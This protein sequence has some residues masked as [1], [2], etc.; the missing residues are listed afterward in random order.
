VLRRREAGP[1]TPLVW[2]PPG[3]Q[4]VQQCCG[5]ERQARPRPWSGGRGCKLGAPAGGRVQ[6]NPVRKQP[7]GDAGQSG[8]CVPGPLCAAAR[9]PGPTHTRIHHLCPPASLLFRLRHPSLPGAPPPVG[10]YESSL[11]GE[12]GGT[13]G[14]PLLPGPLG[15]S[16]G[17]APYV[18]NCV[19][20]TPSSCNGWAGKGFW[21]VPA[22]SLPGESA[23]RTD[24]EDL[25]GFSIL[26]VCGC[27]GVYVWVWVC[28]GGG[29]R[30][31]LGLGLG[32]KEAP[33]Q[34]FAKVV[35]GAN[36]P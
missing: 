31:V 18:P 25:P 8:L 2:R 28:V 32:G 12:Q 26:Q 22:Y 21:E 36:L 1:P 7:A 17:V 10:R 11:K 20:S 23:R 4:D 27:V 33:S 5:G 15:S 19:G 6:G 29:G 16:P 14:E 30:A 13:N 35:G 9:P 3:Q 24:P 34:T